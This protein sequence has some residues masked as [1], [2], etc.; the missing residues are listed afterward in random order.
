MKLDAVLVAAT[1]SSAV[2]LN[3]VA[4]ILVGLE[5]VVP[6]TYILMRV[7]GS[8]L[9]TIKYHNAALSVTELV[10]PTEVAKVPRLLTSKRRALPVVFTIL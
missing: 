9:P 7:L 5:V 4:G 3:I 8:N 2:P 1:S 6:L 10:T